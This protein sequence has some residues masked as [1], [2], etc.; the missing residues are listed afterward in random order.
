MFLERLRLVRGL[1]PRSRYPVE[2]LAPT[3]LHAAMAERLSAPA[4]FTFSRET[5]LGEVFLHW[6]R[7]LDLPLLVDWPALAEVELWPNSTIIC[8]VPDCVWHEAL[9]DVLEPL[10]LD[11][12]AAAGGAIEISS[13][14]QLQRDLQLE[15]YPLISDE[16]TDANQ[17]LSRL[18]EHVSKTQGATTGQS[19][20]E[21]VFDRTAPAILALQPATAQREILALLVEQG[22]FR[23]P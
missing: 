8:A 15:L 19:K 10:G 22:L 9:A 12:R 14:E 13:A 2:R 1:S 3:P 11:W 17:I 18:R 7:E 5:P 21:F 6:Q 4:L 16:P 20:T 23:Q